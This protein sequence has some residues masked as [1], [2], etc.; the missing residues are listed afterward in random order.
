MKSSDH[1]SKR[2]EDFV[3]TFNAKKV[4]QGFSYKSGDNEE[5][6]TVESLRHLIKE[7]VDST[8]EV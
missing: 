1:F 2:S 5:W 7:H 8:F 4:E 6:E 3:K